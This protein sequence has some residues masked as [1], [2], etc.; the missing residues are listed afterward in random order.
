VPLV[1]DP[2]VWRWIWLAVAVTFGLAEL[3]SAGAFFMLPFAVGAAAAA[4]LAFLGLA[5]GLQ[6]LVFLAVSIALLAGLRP[7]AAKLA[8][9]HPAEG[10][11][12]KRLIGQH[13]TVLTEIDAGHQELGLVRL[14]REEWRAESIDGS[15]LPVGAEVRVVEQRGTRVVV[16]A[17]SLPPAAAP[18]SE[19][20]SPSPEPPTD[21][22]NPAEPTNPQ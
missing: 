17:V 21:P 18:A 12:S 5:L 8:R 1:D 13:G 7:L 6:W 14:Q 15:A 4:V 22:S 16:S 3:A 20:P 11:G 19:G 10:I 2:E 9:D